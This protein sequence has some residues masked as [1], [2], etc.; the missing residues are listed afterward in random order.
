MPDLLTFG[1]TIYVK[2]ARISIRK[3]GKSNEDDDWI[4]EILHS[5]STDAGLYEC[6]IS[7]EQPQIH[8]IYL[9]VEGND[10]NNQMGKTT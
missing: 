8:K 4:L 5:K 9:S 7:T 10:N 1:Q 6:Q 3:E 2:D